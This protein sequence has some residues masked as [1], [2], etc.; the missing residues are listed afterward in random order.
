MSNYD[1]YNN[2]TVGE[3]LSIELQKQQDSALKEYLNIERR[4]V[5]NT[6]K[7]MDNS[8]EYITKKDINMSN[9]DDYDC[10]ANNAE[11][12]RKIQN[13]IKIDARNKFITD[14]PQKLKEPDSIQV[15]GTHYKDMVIQPWQVM[16]AL[17]TRDEF[18]GYLK[19]CII[20]YSMRQGKKE[21]SP[22]D[23]QKCQHYIDKLAVILE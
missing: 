20:K 10:S 23:G 9:Y 4:K 11:L 19:G 14:G 3:L 13:Q 21:I 22:M 5:I 18:V 16:E 2:L 17:L 1:G 7:N 8:Q 15:D 6:S 12:N